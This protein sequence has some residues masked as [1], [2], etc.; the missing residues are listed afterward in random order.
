MHLKLSL[1]LVVSLE[2]YLKARNATDASSPA[3]V[4]VKFLYNVEVET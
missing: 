1:P 4:E 2:S 3:S